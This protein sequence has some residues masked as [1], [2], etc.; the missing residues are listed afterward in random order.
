MATPS[1]RSASAAAASGSRS[2]R[3]TCTSA[4]TSTRRC[5]GFARGVRSTSE[6]VVAGGGHYGQ[7]LSLDDAY[8]YWSNPFQNTIHRAPKGGGAAQLL[9]AHGRPGRIAVDDTHVYWVDNT[10]HWVARVPKSPV[11]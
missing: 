9:A 3:R 2:T 10:N 1:N 11:M 8:V 7:Y 4:P 5:G 6:V